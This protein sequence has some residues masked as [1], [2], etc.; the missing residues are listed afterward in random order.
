M[1]I[2]QINPIFIEPAPRDRASHQTNVNSRENSDKGLPV[3][4]LSVRNEKAATKEQIKND[5]EKI[6][7]SPSVMNHSIRF[8]IDESTSE[9]V[10]KIVDKNTDK[11]LKQI[12]PEEVLTLKERIQE[13][14]GLLVEERA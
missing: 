3:Q 11:I 10:V 7:A 13:M 5:L 4:D 2:N 12:P 6:N 1:N 14:R 8:S 9:L